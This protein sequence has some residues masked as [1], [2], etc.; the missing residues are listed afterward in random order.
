MLPDAVFDEFQE[1]SVLKTLRELCLGPRTPFGALLQVFYEPDEWVE[2]LD[3][4]TIGEVMHDRTV[5][6][7]NPDS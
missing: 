7:L 6:V 3:D 5:R 4:E 1:C 2:G